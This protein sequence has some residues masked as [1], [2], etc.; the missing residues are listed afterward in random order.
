MV[1]LGVAVVVVFVVVVGRFSCEWCGCG[2]GV[3]GV[4]WVVFVVL[5]V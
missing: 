1:V 4:L 3:V 2:L 5:V